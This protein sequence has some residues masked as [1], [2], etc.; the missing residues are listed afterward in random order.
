MWAYLKK[1]N[2]VTGFAGAQVKNKLK[3]ALDFWRGGNGQWA[4]SFLSRRSH[5]QKLLGKWKV[6]V[7]QCCFPCWTIMKTCSC[8]HLW[9]YIM[10][11][12]PHICSGLNKV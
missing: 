2:Y 7:L 12:S 11:L 1:D 5:F 3:D 6:A 10:F 4:G 8:F 9:E